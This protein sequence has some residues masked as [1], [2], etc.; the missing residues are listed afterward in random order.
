MAE[1]SV[2]VPN[3]NG[4][5][6]LA[7]LI[8]SLAAQTFKDYEVIFV[9]DCSSD[10]SVPSTI[11][12]LVGRHA[13]MRL[14][15]NERNVGFVKT[16]N[17]GIALADGQ[18]VCLLNNDTE[19]ARE[20]VARNVA[21][22]EADPSI[23]ILSCV[24]VDRNGD[25]WFSGGAINRGIPI[26]L[27]DDFTGVRP[28]DWV[29]GT[30]C[31]YRREVFDKAGPLNEDLFMYHEDVEFCLRVRKSTGYRACMFSDKLV[32]HYRDDAAVK[33]RDFYYYSARNRAL[34]LKQYFPKR[35]YAVRLLFYTTPLEIAHAMAKSPG[36]SARLLAPS[37]HKI[38][39]TWDGLTTRSGQ[40]HRK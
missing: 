3:Y 12:E 28:V 37:F 33:N 23:G 8:D 2:V 9:D 1:V 24:V 40:L 4:K 27:H 6:H 13:N 19:V 21:T 30:A 20:F 38:R 10:R 11:Q 25:N 17:R 16:C 26:I 22:M 32:T 5:E 35:A 7:R 29:A 36:N 14:V 18:Y 15:E 34:V 39:G 31:F